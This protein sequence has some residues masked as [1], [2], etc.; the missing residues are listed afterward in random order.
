[1]QV[2]SQ[3]QDRRE[4]CGVAV[5]IAIEASQIEKRYGRV[6][7]LEHCS[8]RIPE[9]RVVAL[10]GPNG[11]GKTTFLQVVFGLEKLDAGSIEV[12]GLSPATMQT[13]LLP[14][15]GFLA[16]DRPLYK[17]FTVADMLEF[18]RRLNPSWDHALALTWLNHLQIPLG[19][20]VGQLSGGQ[21]AHVALVMVVAKRPE[22]LL[23]DEPVAGLDPLARQEFLAALMEMVRARKLT[24]VL[25]SHIVSELQQTCDYLVILSRGHVQV[26]GEIARLLSAHRLLTGPS[27]TSGSS[28]LDVI[29]LTRNGGQTK[30]LVRTD[31]ESG[32]ANLEGHEVNLEELVLAYLSRDRAPQGSIVG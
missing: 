26:S 10:V 3:R 24:V 8:V 13:D 23:L 20:R 15:V 29:Q 27:L 1:M 25:S 9:G 2:P 4:A 21:Q 16:Q 6:V 17:G 11:A 31:G 5:A 28:G 14:R 7:A 19:R 18:G 22:I 12:L 30:A 32:M